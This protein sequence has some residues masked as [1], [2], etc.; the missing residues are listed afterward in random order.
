MHESK[1]NLFKNINNIYIKTFWSL[2]SS[3]ANPTG[4]QSNV[5]ILCGKK[6]LTM[7]VQS[8]KLFETQLSLIIFDIPDPPRWNS[9]FKRNYKILGIS[10]CTVILTSLVIFVTL[11]ATKEIFNS[12]NKKP[13]RNGYPTDS[14]EQDKV[15]PI[16][17]PEG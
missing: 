17:L 10:F 15:E 9:F 8:L 6:C 11:L 12:A 2:F 1:I 5:Q 13:G 14:S 3:F 16:D 4:I 7:K